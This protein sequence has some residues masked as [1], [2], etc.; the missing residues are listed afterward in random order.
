[1]KANTIFTFNGYETYGWTK[2]DHEIGLIGGEHG[3]WKLLDHQ[4]G[5]DGLVWSGH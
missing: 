1:M 5:T 4:N 3:C 2:N